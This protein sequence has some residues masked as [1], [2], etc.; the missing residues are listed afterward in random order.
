[1]NTGGIGAA[2]TFAETS[3]VNRGL[4]NEVRGTINYTDAQT[5]NGKSSNSDTS[6]GQFI[7][8]LKKRRVK[9]ALNIDSRFRDNYYNTVN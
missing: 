2:A 6:S 1:M 8:P 5:S 4:S 7:N 9:K 3:S